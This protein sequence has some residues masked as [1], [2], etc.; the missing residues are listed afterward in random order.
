MLGTCK[1]FPQR[2][3][4]VIYDGVDI[5]LFN[6]KEKS[7]FREKWVGD[8]KENVIV[9]LL[10]RID[11]FKGHSIFIQAANRIAKTHENVLFLMTGRKMEDQQGYYEEL[12]SMISSERIIFT[13]FNDNV[14][15]VL[16][17]TDISVH[18]SR[19]E[20]FGGV[21]LESMAAGVPVIASKHGGPSE[22]IDDG[23]NG[24]LH[25][26]ANVDELVRYLVILIENKDLRKKMGDEARKKAEKYFTYELTVEKYKERILSVVKKQQRR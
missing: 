7:D 23:I 6:K 2:K 21:V 8:K 3:C 1:G 11:R 22:M 18:A 25:S 24:Y 19:W 12:V 16:R 14:P 15:D 17:G 13:G 26:P 20:A 10:G 4:A 9:T 5:K